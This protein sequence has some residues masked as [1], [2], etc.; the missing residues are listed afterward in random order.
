MSNSFQ[1]ALGFYSPLRAITRRPVRTSPLPAC[2]SSTTPTERLTSTVVMRKLPT[3]LPPSAMLMTQPGCTPSRLPA[4]ISAKVESAPRRT[5]IMVA[6]KERSAGILFHHWR[7]WSRLVA[8]AAKH[9]RTFHT[10]SIDPPRS[11]HRPRSYRDHR[12]PASIA[13]AFD[14]TA[15]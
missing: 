13:L 9:P 15:P 8:L 2:S 7:H 3:Y 6:L 1:I 5:L 11:W 10:S 12:W 4:L 14:A